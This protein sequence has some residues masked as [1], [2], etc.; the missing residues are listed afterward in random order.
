[1]GKPF[2]LTDAQMERLK[3]FYPKNPGKLRADDQRA[4]SG[5]IFINCNGLRWYNAPKGCGPHKSPYNRWTR[6]SNMGMFRG[7]R[8]GLPPR[9]ARPRRS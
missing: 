5:I 1:M 2:W 6:C 3:P 7:S 4:L 9:A 8:R